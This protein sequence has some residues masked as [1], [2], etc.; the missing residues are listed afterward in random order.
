M[1]VAK[2]TFVVVERFYGIPVQF[3]TEAETAAQ[4]S[5]LAVADIQATANKAS[6]QADGVALATVSHAITAVAPKS[7][8][9]GH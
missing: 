7:V 5:L 2:T 6:S 1:G 8:P 9:K 3:E 4:A